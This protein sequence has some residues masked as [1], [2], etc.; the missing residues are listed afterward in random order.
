MDIARNYWKNPNYLQ[1]GKL[2]K[3]IEMIIFQQSEGQKQIL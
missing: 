3:S 1:I 2:Q